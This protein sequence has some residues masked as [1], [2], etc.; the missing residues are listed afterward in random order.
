M[1]VSAVLFENGSTRVWV[2][3]ED[4]SRI[5]TPRTIRTG[6]IADGMVEVLDGLTRDDQVATSDVVFIDRAAKGY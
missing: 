4:K 3:G 2:V 5:L 1:P 6:R